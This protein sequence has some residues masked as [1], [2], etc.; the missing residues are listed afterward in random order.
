MDMEQQLFT[1]LAGLLKT[2]HLEN[3]N[4]IGQLIEVEGADGVAGKLLE[5]RHRLQDDRI[6]Y[7]GGKRWIGGWSEIE[8]SEQMVSIPWKDEGV[9]LLT[10]GAG[11]L[12]MIFAKEIATQARSANLIL[13]GRS[14]LTEEQEGKLQELQSLGARVE[15]KQVDV[16]NKEEIER[17]LENIRREYGSL[18]GI[19]H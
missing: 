4:F 14:L 11:G 18:N 7:Q 13:T 3:P 9:Y 12:G 1:G 19:L 2:A 8:A 16:A 15:Y 17:L 10:G 6:R 5:N